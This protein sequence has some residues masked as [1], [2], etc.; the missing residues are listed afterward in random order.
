MILECSKSEGRLFL[1]VFYDV[2]PSQIRNLTGTYAE[3]FAKH[4]VRFGDEKG[5][6]QKWRDALRQAANVSGW[7]FQPGY[8]LHTILLFVFFFYFFC[9]FQ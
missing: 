1:P 2:D 6:V 3:A 9:I 5:K 8:V 4:E 7:Y